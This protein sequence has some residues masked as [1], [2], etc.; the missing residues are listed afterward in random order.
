MGDLISTSLLA[1]NG[2]AGAAAGPDAATVSAGAFG[3]PWVTSEASA[4]APPFVPRFSLI[5]KSSFSSSNSVTEFFLIRSIM[6]LMS[7]KSTAVCIRA[8]VRCSL[9]PDP[10]QQPQGQE[11][12]FDSAFE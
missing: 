7:F 2:G 5:L 12:C 8:N 1:G 10:I 3:R 4:A 11:P 6:A 9:V